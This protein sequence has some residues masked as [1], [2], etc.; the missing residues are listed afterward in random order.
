MSWMG[1][2]GVDQRLCV[3]E[4]TDLHAGRE[5]MRNKEEENEILDCFHYIYSHPNTL[6]NKEP[7]D[8]ENKRKDKVPG[9][10]RDFRLDELDGVGRS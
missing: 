9:Q 8:R 3:C 2:G 7:R 10:N 5:P 6:T 4:D 1:L